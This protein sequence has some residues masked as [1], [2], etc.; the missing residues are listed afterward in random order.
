MSARIITR[1]ELDEQGC[2]NPDCTGDHAVIYLQPECHPGGGFH[3]RYCKA[4]GTM[5][6]E[7]AACGKDHYPI[8]IAR[9]LQ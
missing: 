7:C 9:R 8:Q 5:T 1:E 6:F 4:D 3:V 2:S